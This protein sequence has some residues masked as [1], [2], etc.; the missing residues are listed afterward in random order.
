VANW[1]LD[2]VTKNLVA[3]EFTI[4]DTTVVEVKRAIFA[5]AAMLCRL[6]VAD[7]SGSGWWMRMEKDRNFSSNGRKQQIVLC[8]M[9]AHACLIW[10][11]Q[12]QYQT[13]SR[14]VSI[15]V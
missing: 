4:L 8:E 13:L 9:T 5:A 7:D 6:L 2:E 11:G 15:S 10:G 3:A 12:S 1:T 14:S